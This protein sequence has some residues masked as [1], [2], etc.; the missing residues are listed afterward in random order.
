MGLND[1]PAESPESIPA[2]SP[3][4]NSIDEREVHDPHR[5]QHTA[6]TIA[7]K[8][9]IEQLTKVYSTMSNKQRKYTHM[10]LSSRGF[11]LQPGL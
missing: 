9:L 3:E 5:L 11:P 6:K 4:P 1:L 2:P 7:S 10:L 8:V